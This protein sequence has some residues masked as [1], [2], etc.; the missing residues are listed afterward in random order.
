MLHGVVVEGVIGGG[1]L[2][3]GLIIID[4]MHL[5]FRLFALTDLFLYL[6]ILILLETHVFDI[7]Y[8]IIATFL[9]LLFVLRIALILTNHLLLT[10]KS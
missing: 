2:A 1:L 9:D 5:F 10:F 7:H 6:N 4:V 8:V 3:E